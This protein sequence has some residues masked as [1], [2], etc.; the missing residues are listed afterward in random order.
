M[1]QKKLPVLK[2]FLISFLL[3]FSFLNI[4]AQSVPY[5]PPLAHFGGSDVNLST[6][7][8]VEGDYTLE[9]AGTV[10]VEIS[11]AGGF[12]VYT[13]TENGNVR[14]AQRNRRIF[15]YEGNVYKTTL[16]PTF[17][18][19]YPT[20]TDA[21]AHNNPANL[22]QNASFETAGSL[23]G[24]TNYR[25]GT[26]WVTSVTV[27]SSGGIR[28]T[29]ATAGN[30]N[31]TWELV[32]RGTANSSY[33]AQQLSANIKSNT[34][35]KI[36]ARQISGSN[37]NAEYNFGFGT[38]V[39]GMEY[40]FNPIRLGLG[41]NGTHEVTVKTP[42]NVS[43]NTYFTVRNTATMTALHSD[44]GTTSDRDPLTQLDYLAL[45]QAELTLPSEGITGVSSAY[46]LDDIAF[47]TMSDWAA[48]GSTDAALS[49][50]T[51]YGWSASPTITWT[52][53]NTS[54]VGAVRYIDLTNGT[55]TPTGGVTY[56]HLGNNY[57]G[58]MMFVR[59][60]GNPSRVYS[61][62]VYLEKDKLYSFSGKAAYHSVSTA[63]T[64]SI[65]INQSAI[66]DG[67]SYGVTNI[68]TGSAGDLKDGSFIFS[69]PA[70]GT[71]YLTF[72]SS[73]AS[74]NAV[75]DL[76]IS[77][78]SNENLLIENSDHSIGS[79]ISAKSMTVR[80][81]LKL[82]VNN[83]A[84]LN[85]ASLVLEGNSDGTATFLNN[86]TA[87]ITS[88]TVQR[89]LTAGRNWYFASPVSNATSGVV[90]SV[91]AN[92]LWKRDVQGNDWTPVEVVDEDLTPGRGYV[93]KT[94]SSGNISFTGTLNDG[95][96][97]Y[98]LVAYPGVTGG[99]FHLVGNPYPSY[100][101][102]QSVVSQNSGILPT[103]WFRTRTVEQLIGEPAVPTVS[104]T[105]ATVQYVNDEL[106]IVNGNANTTISG[107]IP[108]MQGFWV[109][110]KDNVDNSS[111]AV[112]KN[113]RDHAD[114][115]GNKFKAPA[116]TSTQ[117]LRL[118]VSN[119]IYTDET[120]LKFNPNASDSFDEFDSPKMFNNI[121]AI[122]EIY[123]LVG[124]EKL[125]I[126]GL[127]DYNY[128]TV[129]PLGLVAGQAGSFAIRASQLQNLNSDTQI[130]LL[131]K[132]NNTQFN[133]TEGES[134]NFTADATDTENRF[135]VLF[136]SATGTTQLDENVVSG[137]YLSA[138]DGRLTLQLNTAIDNAKVTVF[139]SSGQTI[140]SQNVQGQTTVLN[141]TLNAGVYLVKVEN[142]GRS[143]VL[144]TVVR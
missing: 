110:M 133:L 29:Q 114:Q 53:A 16:T 22:L 119:G 41:K 127:S 107:L 59:W 52:A 76:V 77:D 142:N 87:N 46:Y 19:T 17:T 92:S 57:T 126:N 102:W 115:S 58:R 111:F 23:V 71:Y 132:T 10:G 91:E 104:W 121:A 32:W 120:L 138:K 48:Y 45:V 109:R 75:A 82:S 135:A 34:S 12:Y 100:L 113:M 38:T 4:H 39:N 47:A 33:F 136:K 68:V 9:V 56:K 143:V 73:T 54:T 42:S 3:L 96:V 66:N 8:P 90:K 122:P 83:G 80:P 36:I 69:V 63:G 31:G 99:R 30:V 98:S 118:E 1:N 65:G 49:I 50:P 88:A 139:S 108:A 134:Y 51:V 61:Y 112:N 70:D 130:W 97:S 44:G 74:L 60:D 21:D 93:A 89:H 140:H 11:V 78:I 14:F 2:S 81:G 26:P 24:G 5:L 86:G 13:P 7:K 43:D 95:P 129:I 106:D 27:P 141:K 18:L 28:F 131:D 124:D 15:V 94:A 137:I 123:T 117:R 128:N 6:F 37:S 55:S 67:T 85:I 105:F 116:N 64:L 40:V 62:P 84:Q 20:I 125:V 25:F 101:N 72:T 79:H 103:M 144:R 35:Y